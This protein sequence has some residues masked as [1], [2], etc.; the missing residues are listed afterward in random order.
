MTWW[1]TLIALALVGGLVAVTAAGLQ[2]RPPP[3]LEVQ[4]GTATRGPITRTVTGAGKVQPAT[5]V[6]ISSSLS[7][8]LVERTVNDGDPVSRGQ[9]LGR[10][11]RRRFEANV[12]QAQAAQNAA[13]SDV[14][15]AMVEVERTARELAR[16]QG[17][18]AK[19][20]SSQAEVEVAQAALAGANARVT[21]LRD[22]VSQQQAVLDEAQNNLQKTALVSP[23]DGTVI[24][25]NREVGERVRGSDFNEDVV[26]SLAALTS[27]EVKFEVGEHEVVHLAA[28]Q[29]G[30]V[31]IDALEGQRFD[32]T[33]T[34]IA[35]KALIRAQGTEQETT[36]FPITV[37]L[38]SRPPGV[39]PG[40]SAEVRITA[41]QRESAITVPV[42]A[43]TVRP[44]SSLGPP[45]VEG[46]PSPPRGQ[47]GEKFARVVFVVGADQKV[48]LRRVRTGIAS[49]TDLEVV[50]GLAEGERVVEG[51]Y[52]TLAK[53]LKDG[54][55]VE[56]KRP[57]QGGRRG[58]GRD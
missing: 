30:Q 21:A 55:A 47:G 2:E 9:L 44:E 31:K 48:S 38:T 33:V 39:M 25:C 10:L 13:K 26:M 5:T 36:S 37:A 35:Q 8:D 43:V 32:G 46:R 54:D 58:P 23:I 56:E 50:E 12:R 1:R 11:D 22:R 24:E 19:G 53:D 42:Q 49:D 52:R 20:L 51:P 17:L 40:M 45:L 3:P 34:E 6:K 29:K 15:T 18:A 27:M 7:G 14:A 4:V 28:G 57:G 16:V 41:E